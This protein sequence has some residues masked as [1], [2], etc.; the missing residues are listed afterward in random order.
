MGRARCKVWREKIER[1][2]IR[3]ESWKG[4]GRGGLYLI[5]NDSEE[6]PVFVGGGGCGHC[7]ILN[8]STARKWE[9]EWEGGREG[10]K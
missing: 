2:R 5:A 6:M 1:R 3:A 10:V 7:V 9:E 8:L 4:G